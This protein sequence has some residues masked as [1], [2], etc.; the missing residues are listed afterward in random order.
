MQ[1]AKHVFELGS[2][3]GAFFSKPKG[4]CAL[5]LRIFA[6]FNQFGSLKLGNHVGKRRCADADTVRYLG[7]PDAISQS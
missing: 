2:Q 4:F 6:T 1:F 5:I 7:L 3:G